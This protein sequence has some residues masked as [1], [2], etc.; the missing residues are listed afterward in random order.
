MI[1][2][3]DIE[4]KGTVIGPSTVVI[5]DIRGGSAATARPAGAVLVI[6]VCDNGVD[7]TNAVFPDIVIN[8]A[9]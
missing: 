1:I 3:E 8:A 9:V 6:W 7:P 5:V 4:H 2:E